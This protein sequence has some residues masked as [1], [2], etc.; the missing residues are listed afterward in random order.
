[1]VLNE[2]DALDINDSVFYR[3]TS[4]SNLAAALPLKQLRRL[5]MYVPY[6]TP[7]P[8]LHFVQQLPVLEELAL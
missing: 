2:V 5:S 7:Q 8:L 3:S 1:L 6:S 4:T